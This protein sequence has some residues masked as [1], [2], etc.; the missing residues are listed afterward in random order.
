[1]RSDKLLPVMMLIPVFDQGKS[2]AGSGL[3]L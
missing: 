2:S 3:V 1:M